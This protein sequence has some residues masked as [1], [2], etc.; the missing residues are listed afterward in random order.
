MDV[1][2]NDR[3]VVVTVPFARSRGV[4]D[5]QGSLKATGERLPGISGGGS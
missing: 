2:A 3:P 4:A 1:T 5:A